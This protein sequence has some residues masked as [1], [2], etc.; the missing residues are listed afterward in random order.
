[1]PLG[2]FKGAF[3]ILKNLALN[4]PMEQHENWAMLFVK[5]V[6]EHIMM[7]KILNDLNV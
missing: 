3:L 4:N 7:K 5:S 2:S 1:M 6:L